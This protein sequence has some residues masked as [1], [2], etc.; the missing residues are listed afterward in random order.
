M[1]KFFLRP[2]AIADLESI[3]DYTVDTWDVE[4]AERYVRMINR[5]FGDLAKDS[6]LGRSC[7]VIREGYRKHLVGRHV[8]FYRVMDAGI[9]VVRVLHQRMDFK[10]HL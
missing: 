6:V 8:I 10:R 3:W 7:D 1:A 5:A 9:D 4:Q 2:K